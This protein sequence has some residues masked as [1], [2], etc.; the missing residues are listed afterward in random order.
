VAIPQ[1]GT[2]PLGFVARQ[3]RSICS[4]YVSPG[5][6]G[7]SVGYALL[8]RAVDTWPDATK[9]MATDASKPLFERVGFAETK[10]KGRYHVMERREG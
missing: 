8:R 10:K 6:R 3:G 7:L 1:D 2:P 4:L 9:A 5:S